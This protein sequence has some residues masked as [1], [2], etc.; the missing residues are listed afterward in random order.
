MGVIVKM[1]K[2]A[3]TLLDPFGSIIKVKPQQIRNRRD[4]ARAVTSDLNGRPITAKD[5]VMVMDENGANRRQSQVLHIYRTFVYC[6]SRDFNENGGVFVT[7]NSNVALMT[8]Q[9]NG[10]NQMYN[11]QARM[12]TAP[13]SRRGYNSF[14][15][16]LMGKTVT[17]NGGPFKGYLGI[18]KDVSE[19]QARVELHTNSRTVTFEKDK[20]TV[21]GEEGVQ[22][23]PNYQASRPQN[24]YDTRTPMHT[25]S[26]TPAWDAGSKTPA[27]DSGSKTPAWDAGSKTP[28]WDAGS[29]TPAWESSA[30]TPAAFGRPTPRAPTT[31]GNVPTPYQ[32]GPTPGST[33]PTTPGVSNT[34]YLGGRAQTP[35]TP[36]DPATVN[37]P[38]T[39]AGGMGSNDYG[40]ARDST[41]KG[42]WITVDIEVRVSSNRRFSSGK[43]D[44]QDGVIK[45]VDGNR[46]QIHLLSTGESIL[47][48]EEFLVPVAPQKK[49]SFKVLS[50][51]DRGKI[52]TLL[53]IDGHEG[54][55]KIEGVDDILMM[56]L[57][58]L[59]KLAA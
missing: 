56:N 24:R 45:Q 4:S 23:R 21:K 43:L 48:A 36:Y 5:T 37:H 16:P 18:V 2:D 29:K 59:A 13:T 51:E 12:V 6:H 14:K 8:A 58:T 25:G 9:G 1:E 40:R 32:S 54:V 3:F 28:A 33:Y 49:D 26:R 42:S 11:N 57:D 55:V 10:S 41:G 50:G 53:S 22:R 27:W 17:I 47:I 7:K 52:G 38:Q 15:D 46:A 20:L 39:P 35:A 44:G 34:P 30:R 31:P 19:T